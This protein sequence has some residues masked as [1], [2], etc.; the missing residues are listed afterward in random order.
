MPKRNPTK[1]MELVISG[2][3]IDLSI[4]RDSGNTVFIC[5][6]GTSKA[7]RDNWAALRDL[8]NDALEVSSKSIDLDG[9]R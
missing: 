3:R 9:A 4:E 1:K 6:G 7:I 5:M 8:C 2:N